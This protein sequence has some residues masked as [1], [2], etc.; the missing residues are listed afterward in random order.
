MHHI[1]VH[2]SHYWNPCIHRTCWVQTRRNDVQSSSTPALQ[3]P[4]Y[5]LQHICQHQ[6]V[7]SLRSSNSVILTVP[8][9]KTAAY[10][11][12]ISASTVW[13]SLPYVVRE[14]SSQTQ[15]LRRL[16]GHLFQ[17]VF[18]WHWSAST[19]SLSTFIMLFLP[20]ASVSLPYLIMNLWSVVHKSSDWLIDWLG[21]VRASAMCASCMYKHVPWQRWC[22]RQSPDD[23]SS[24]PT[25][26]PWRRCTESL[27]VDAVK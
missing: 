23:H 6:P 18:G 3:Q 16:K 15:F 1:V 9:T 22:M 8:S 21:N 2:P 14:T 26:R 7:R 20:I 13:N 11:F 19:W 27:H 25:W 10:A 5:L 12:R 24:L 4:S 17:R